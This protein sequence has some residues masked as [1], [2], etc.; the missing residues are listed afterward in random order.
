MTLEQFVIAFIRD[1]DPV[2]E[3]VV[4]CSITG[5][6]RANHETFLGD[7]MLSEEDVRELLGAL[8]EIFTGIEDVVKIKVPV[9]VG[10]QVLQFKKAVLDLE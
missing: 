9:D 8:L 1:I 2:S 6:W 10:Y 7:E 5:A 4:W 3:V